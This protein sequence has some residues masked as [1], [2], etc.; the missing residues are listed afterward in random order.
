MQSR[1]KHHVRLAQLK[2]QESLDLKNDQSTDIATVPTYM[3]TQVGFQTFL[4]VKRYL[5]KTVFFKDDA[6][7]T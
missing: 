7:I 3:S 6:E 4:D 1:K 2:K 5:S